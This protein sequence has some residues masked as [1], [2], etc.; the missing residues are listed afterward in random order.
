M[1]EEIQADT[2]NTMLYREPSLFAF[3]SADENTVVSKK[4]EQN[5]DRFYFLSSNASLDTRFKKPLSQQLRN[6]KI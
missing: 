3:P 5:V 1:K 6:R 4:R 2:R